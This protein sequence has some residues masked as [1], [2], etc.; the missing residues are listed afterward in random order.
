MHGKSKAKPEVKERS[1]Q[2][3]TVWDGFMANSAVHFLK[4]RRLRRMVLL[5][6]SGHIDRW[7]GIPDRVHKQTGGKVLTIRVELKEENKKP[8]EEKVA[9]YLIRVR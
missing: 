2:V 9:D 8:P 6:G 4:E 1:Y 5:A 7:F 3:M